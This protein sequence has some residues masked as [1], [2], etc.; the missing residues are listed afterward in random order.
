M[1]PEQLSGDDEEDHGDENAAYAG[2]S[3]EKQD[4]E[5][6]QQQKQ[7]TYKRY[8]ECKGAVVDGDFFDS[9]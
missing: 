2:V 1:L 3:Q 6:D 5:T 8:E 4:A 7:Q 9:I